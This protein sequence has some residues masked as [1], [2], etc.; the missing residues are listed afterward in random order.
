MTGKELHAAAKSG[1]GSSDIQIL[2]TQFLQQKI[3]A[4]LTDGDVMALSH[5]LTLFH[6]RTVIETAS[7]LENK[8]EA[9]INAHNHLF[10]E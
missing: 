9:I 5:T 3:D 2:I 6:H 1:K 8:V 4:P 7:K 10:D